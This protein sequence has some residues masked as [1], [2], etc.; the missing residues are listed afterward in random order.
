M[1]LLPLFDPPGNLD[2]F[3]EPDLRRQW[4]RLIGG[5]FKGNIDGLTAPGVTPQFYDPTKTETASPRRRSGVARG[6]PFQ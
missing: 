3:A 4:S 2:D 6:G 1:P 5:F